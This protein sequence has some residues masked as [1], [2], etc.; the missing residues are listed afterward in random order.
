MAKVRAARAA[1]GL[2]PGDPAEDEDEEG[3]E[4]EDSDDD[5]GAPLMRGEE[6]LRELERRRLALGL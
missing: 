5:T 1:L 3:E 4:G 2:P 6:V